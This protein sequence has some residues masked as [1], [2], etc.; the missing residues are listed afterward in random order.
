[1]RLIDQTTEPEWV[2]LP[3]GGRLQFRIPTWEEHD[4]V[5]NR[6]ADEMEGAQEITDV[7]RELAAMQMVAQ[8]G[9]GSKDGDGNA[10]PAKLPDDAARIVASLSIMDIRA[11]ERVLYRRVEAAEG[12][13]GN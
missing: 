4:R 10:V 6:L 13:L 2:D 7:T 1:M 12:D 5:R 3:D 11:V 8:E 9:F